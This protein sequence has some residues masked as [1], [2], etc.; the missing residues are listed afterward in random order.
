MFLVTAL[1]PYFAVKSAMAISTAATEFFPDSS[2]YAPDWSLSTPSTILSPVSFW[3]P[4]DWGPPPPQPATSTTAADATAT[5]TVLRM[6]TPSIPAR[7]RAGR[8]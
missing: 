2:E 7:R 5:P 1:S 4:P 8:R 3:S 6:P